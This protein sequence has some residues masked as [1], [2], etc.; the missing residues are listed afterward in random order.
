[1]R[2]R[3]VPA[4]EPVAPVEGVGAG[5]DSRPVEAGVPGG[6]QR[7][8]GRKQEPHVGDSGQVLEAVHVGDVGQVAAQVAHVGPGHGGHR[9]VDVEL[10]HRLALRVPGQVDVARIAVRRDLPDVGDVGCRVQRLPAIAVVDF[11]NPVRV[12][13]RPHLHARVPDQVPYRLRHLARLVRRGKPV[14]PPYGLR[15]R[16]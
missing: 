4:H 3:E 11:Q 13:Q 14:L 1:L 16:R 5:R 15:Y 6:L 8:V 2:D 9:A 10:L 7:A 12:Q